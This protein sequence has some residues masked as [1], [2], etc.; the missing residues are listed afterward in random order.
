MDALANYDSDDE[1]DEKHSNFKDD[2][3]KLNIAGDN[4][5]NVQ[6]DL[7]EGQA[8]GQDRVTWGGSPV[9]VLVRV[10]PCLCVQENSSSSSKT[11]GRDEVQPASTQHLDRVGLGPLGLLNV[12]NGLEED[13][14]GEAHDEFGCS[15]WWLAQSVI[16]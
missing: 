4:Y 15:L 5:D 1:K 8:Y 3:G 16:P 12:S 14:D 9:Y 2:A 11:G 13:V 6:M 10:S 7:S